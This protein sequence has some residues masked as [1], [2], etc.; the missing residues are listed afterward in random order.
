VRPGGQGCL[1]ALCGHPGS[2]PR[3]LNAY[4]ADARLAYARSGG[5][6]TA[7]L[8]G[9]EPCA[10]WSGNGSRDQYAGPWNRHTASPILLVGITGDSQLPYQDDLAM[11]HDLA[12]ARLLTIRGYG[13]TEIANP[14]P[15]A[16]NYELSY[17]QTAALPPVGTTCQQDATPFP[18]P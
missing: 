10:Q 2:D 4:A 15:C 17:L 7:Q 6:G 12:R 3:N 16:T 1:P 14:S 9:S 8:W 11:A 5:F 13:H 18:A